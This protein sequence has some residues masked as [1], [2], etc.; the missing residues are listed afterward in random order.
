MNAYKTMKQIP[1]NRYAII[2]ADPPWSVSS[3]RKHY[4]TMSPKKIAALP[5]ERIAQKDAM[6]FLW[7]TCNMVKHAIQIGEGWGF[8]LKTIGFA[9]IKPEK[10]LGLGNYTRLGMEPCLLFRRGR[11]L[12]VIMHDVRQVLLQERGPHSKKPADFL[13]RM[14]RM[15]GDV[16]RIELFGRGAPA[17]GWDIHGDQTYTN[18][19]M[20]EDWS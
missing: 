8:E 13:I 9:W 6:L 1:A 14:A 16:P 2:C 10:E 20:V 17:V 18:K 5:V 19:Q 12:P 3:A 11:G 7:S 4:K 15:H